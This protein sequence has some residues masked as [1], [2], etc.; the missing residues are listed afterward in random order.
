MALGST[1]L[2]MILMISMASESWKNVLHV[3]PVGFIWVEGQGGLYFAMCMVTWLLMQTELRSGIE[4]LSFL[5]TSWKYTDRY[6][7]F[8]WFKKEFGFAQ[9]ADDEYFHRFVHF[10][11]NVL[12]LLF[13]LIAFVRFIVTYLIEMMIMVQ[14]FRINKKV[15]SGDDEFS[16]QD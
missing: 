5:W 9:P 11:E 12:K 7:N 16:I 13:V 14:I 4:F 8:S 3:K 10:I 2:Q 6:I 1:A 15:L